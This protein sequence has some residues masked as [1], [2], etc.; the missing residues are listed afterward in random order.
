MSEST[1]QSQDR[2]NS[3]SLEGT[4]SPPN[5]SE[6]QAVCYYRDYVT[7]MEKPCISTSSESCP[8]Y[9]ALPY[10]MQL[11]S[12]PTPRTSSQVPLRSS[13]SE[14]LLESECSES[15]PI[16]EVLLP[17]ELNVM[18]YAQSRAK[19]IASLLAE[20]EKKSPKLP[21]QQ[22]PRHMRR[23]AA[24]HN[25]KRLPRRLRDRAAKE[26]N[27]TKSSKRPSRRYRRRPSNL[28][29]EYTRRQRQHI[30]LETHIW[31][32]KRFK[33]TEMWGYKLPLH[34][35]DKSVRAAYRASVHHVLLQDLSYY[36]CI[37]LVGTEQKLLQGLSKFTS[38]ETGLTF[39]AKFYLKGTR[40]GS[41]MLYHPTRY[42]YGAIGPVKFLW[43]PESEDAQMK[44]P[45]DRMRQL[46]IWVH[47]SCYDE[48]VTELAAVFELQKKSL[49]PMENSSLKDKLG[50]I[51]H[52]YD[53]SLLTEKDKGIFE[54]AKPQDLKK[55]EEEK[56]LEQSQGSSCGSLKEPI[57]M[58]KEINLSNEITIAKHQVI[59]PKISRTKAMLKKKTE[60]KNDDFR[61]RYFERIQIYDNKDVTMVILKDTLV[62]F[63]LTGPLAQAVIMDVLK[64]SDVNFDKNVKVDNQQSAAM[65]TEEDKSIKW[66][67]KYYSCESAKVCL[68]KQKQIWEEMKE[69]Q[70]PAEL[71]RN[72][73]FGL[74]VQD[75]RLDLPKTRTKIMNNSK[76]SCDETHPA[77]VNWLQN[78]SSVSLSPLWDPE[79][80]D[81]VIRT[82]MS[83]S[84]INKLRS[85]LLIPGSR[86]DL[87]EDESR[88]PVLL[89]QNPGCEDPSCSNLG[90]GSG[91]DLIL[92]AG[93]ARSFWIALIYR[94]ARASGLRELN[95]VSFE[96]GVPMYPSHYADTKSGNMTAEKLRKEL[97]KKH[98]RYPPDK[99]PS[100]EKLSVQ[101]P[102]FNPWTELVNE[103]LAEFYKQLESKNMRKDESQTL[104]NSILPLKRKRNELEYTKSKS[105]CLNVRADNDTSDGLDKYTTGNGTFETKHV[106]T[107]TDYPILHDFSNSKSE[108]L[109]NF[110]FTSFFVLRGKRHL[111][112]LKESCDFILQHKAKQEKANKLQKSDIVQRLQNHLEKI[113]IL[114]RSVVW[115]KVSL[116]GRGTPCQF[117]T[118][119]IPTTDDITILHKDPKFGGPVEPRKKTQ[120]T[121]STPELKPGRN[122]QLWK[123][124]QLKKPEVKD[125]LKSSRKIIGFI[126]TGGFSFVHA[127]GI[128]FGYCAFIGIQKLLAVACENH[129]QPVVLVRDQN[130]FQYRFA[131]INVLC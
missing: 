29:A 33:M 11:S 19:E 55:C 6:C 104:G 113:P 108:M 52:E 111:R 95:S 13:Q 102:F 98:Y 47:P 38:L 105:I 61:Q 100:F 118:I 78:I 30:W 125:L 97:T 103:W 21:M 84:E 40:E 94:G 59:K 63:R 32:A 60:D 39:A 81:E 24:S 10:G 44:P 53:P 80:R 12:Q 67:Q 85:H 82:K 58:T 112:V 71:P 18:K 79:T 37:E 91:W 34:P 57:P 2:K 42:P 75:P 120:R 51:T 116:I 20:V 8:K 76:V 35:N 107:G 101:S 110:E 36:G 65:E 27:K 73:V 122:K 119:S 66:W 23:R 86:L 17:Y 69:V 7:Q 126:E 90:Y 129:A 15:N 46:W 41:V 9:K 83:E 64:V 121:K 54:Q 56:V 70:S 89:I 28:L 50:A 131:M 43:K 106:I 115:V 93:W 4:S 14:F 117:A 114:A 45:A 72:M 62:R 127:R 49:L 31:F 5:G 124:E 68:E 92:P 130:S 128:G 22:L 87:G 1:S 3:R 26:I 96:T 77:I 99:R 48:L 25:V 16:S 88:I 74:T 109:D 123:K